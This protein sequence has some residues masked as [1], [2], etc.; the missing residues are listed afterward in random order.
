MSLKT[1][2]VAVA[3]TWSLRFLRNLAQGARLLPNAYYDAR[4]YLIYSGINRSRAYRR[5]EAARIAMSF[6]QIEKGLSYARPRPGFGKEV[7]DRLLF[8]LENY[9]ARYGMC[10]P[11]QVALS[12]LKRY[13]E[14]NES[15][16]LPVAELR[17]RIE[18]LQ[19]G[20]LSIGDGDEIGGTI[21][22][23]RADIDEARKGSFEKFFV[24][25]HSV[26]HFSGGQVPRSDVEEAVRLAQKTPSVCNRQ[27]W[28]VH[29]FTAADAKAR[30]LSIQRGS[31]GFGEQASLVLVITCDLQQFVNV[32]ERYQAWIDGGM[33]SMS[34]CLAFHSLG[35]G[36]CCLNWS[37]ERTD[38]VALRKTAELKPEEQ[39]IMLIAVGTLPDT[40]KV[41]Y[42]ARRPLEDALEFH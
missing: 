40:F 33:F 4:R 28:K 12:V 37:K 17:S 16:G 29:A 11:T 21:T 24:M 23:E 1:L 32:G 2:V 9:I 7:V 42:S 31:R 39:V 35:Y 34:L 3:P 19:N 27:A 38:D 6:H 10:H 13:I 5:A 25:R 22:V 20:K 15:A 18:A 41:A 36:S 14:F 30:L 8:D 26:R